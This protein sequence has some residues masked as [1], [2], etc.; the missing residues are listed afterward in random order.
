M[1]SRFYYNQGVPLGHCFPGVKWARPARNT[2]SMTL[3]FLPTSSPFHLNFKV[4]RSVAIQTNTYGHTFRGQT[5]GLQGRKRYST[6]RNGIRRNKTE[7]RGEGPKSRPGSRKFLPCSGCASCASY[8]W[9][10]MLLLCLHWRCCVGMRG[11]ACSVESLFCVGCRHG[12]GVLC[13]VWCAT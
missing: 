10:S 5:K 13:C 3:A 12:M 7:M 6:A 1:S 9:T 2:F 8:T 11:T 4:R